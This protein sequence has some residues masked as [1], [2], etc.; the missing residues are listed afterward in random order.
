VELEEQE[1]AGLEELLQ[2]LQVLL[3]QES[4]LEALVVVATLE[5]ALTT[6][7][8]ELEQLLGAEALVV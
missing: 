1:E 6:P 5:V 4:S 2:Q 7:A 3:Q 8:K